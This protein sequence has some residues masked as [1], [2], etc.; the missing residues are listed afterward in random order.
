MS[1]KAV[2]LAVRTFGLSG[3][4]DCPGEEFR[5]FSSRVSLPRVPDKELPTP[6][7]PCS[8]ASRDT[9][10]P[11]SRP[12]RE[13]VTSDLGRAQPPPT[14]T[15]D[16]HRRF[17]RCYAVAGR[18]AHPKEGHSCVVSSGLRPSTAS[19]AV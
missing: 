7:R 5:S 1:R 19:S 18:H 2:D 17:W 16:S 15:R 12:V 14:V 6:T 13:A 11:H 9:G 3:P 4:G 10:R 8:A